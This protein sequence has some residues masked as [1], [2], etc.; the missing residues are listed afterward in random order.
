MTRNDEYFIRGNEE[1]YFELLGCFCDQ[2]CA[3][4]SAFIIDEFCFEFTLAVKC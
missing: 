3:T 2:D 1:L 4:I